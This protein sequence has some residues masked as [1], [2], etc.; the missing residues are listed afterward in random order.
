MTRIYTGKR[1]LAH[2]IGQLAT[3]VL[4][5]RA[6]PTDRSGAG[7]GRPPV[8][9]RV[10]HVLAV[11]GKL[12]EHAVDSGSLAADALAA[13]FEVLDDRLWPAELRPE[14]GGPRSLP[15]PSS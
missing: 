6:M 10:N 4:L 14:G 2:G 5:P 1:S 12:F 13:R 15:T 11:V 3:S 7:Q 9:A 8:G